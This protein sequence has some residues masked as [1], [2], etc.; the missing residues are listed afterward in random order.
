M[1]KGNTVDEE[2]DLMRVQAEEHMIE[3]RIKTLFISNTIME[4]VDANKI[5]DDDSNL[6]Y[7]TVVSR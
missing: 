2:L 1:E 7:C 5:Y 3:E 4:K 6:R